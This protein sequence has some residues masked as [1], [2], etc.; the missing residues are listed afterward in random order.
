MTIH[1]T[2]RMGL[3]L[4]VLLSTVAALAAADILTQL[5]LTPAA[6][7]ETFISALSTTVPDY[8]QASRAFKAVS[9]PA[10]AQLAEG[11]IAWFKTYTASPEFKAA[12]AK[13]REIRKP[14]APEFKGTPEEELAA[15]SAQQDA[16]M[17]KA[18]ASM[19]P[20][21]RKEMEATMKQAAATLSSPEMK[22]MMLDGL[23]RERESKTERYKASLA[24]WAEEYPE[25][26]RPAIARKLQAFLAM[27]AD[28][29]FSAPLEKKDGLMRF[30]N[31]A[32]ED[33]PAE[34]KLCYRAGKDTVTA[35]RAAAQAWLKELGQ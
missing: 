5:G 29:D 28:V 26:P 32:Y 22:K 4:F 25:D 33:K 35:A 3:A 16:E 6:A 27:S 8:Y 17:K 34:W 21:L 15:T 1:L 31:P 14:R 13:M 10:R 2:R 11:A 12:Y 19:P 18:L 23:R 7:K 9:G 20:D 24:A 30:V